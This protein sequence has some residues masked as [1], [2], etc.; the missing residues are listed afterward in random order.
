M[1]WVKAHEDTVGNELADAL[2]KRGTTTITQGCEPW[3][4]ISNDKIKQFITS[5]IDRVWQNRWEL[6]VA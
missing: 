5:H 4:P 3:L 1:E 2:A 6:H